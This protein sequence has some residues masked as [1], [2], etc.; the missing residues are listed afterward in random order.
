MRPNSF[1]TFDKRR[2]T[3]DKKKEKDARGGSDH[4]G[5]CMRVWASNEARTQFRD[6]E[7]NIMDAR[8]F[9]PRAR[10]RP[11]VLGGFFLG[12]DQGRS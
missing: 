11:Q 8:K 3:V 5:V 12:L 1:G 6:L 4:E 9:A 2:G 10:A 7:L